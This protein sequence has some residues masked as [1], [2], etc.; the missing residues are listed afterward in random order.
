MAPKNKFSMEQIINAAFE[1]AKKEGIDGI[2]IRKVADLLGSSIAPIYVNFSDVK[3]LKQAVIKKVVQL[4]QQL[5]Y[6]QNSGSPFQDIGL[7]SIQFA[8]EYPV[9]SKDFIMKP[10]E[11]VGDYDEGMGNELVEHMKKDPDLV[12]FTDQELMMILFKMR[13]FQT[14]LTIMISNK[15][16]PEE[17][18][19]DEMQA[20]MNDVALDVIMAT[21]MRKQKDQ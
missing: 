6:E 14:G 18:D 5:V 16:V 17:F 20:I 21:R 9:L 1:I 11:Y 8:K 7:A 19:L 15:T 12:G 2:T 13:A 4:S 3:E 10:N